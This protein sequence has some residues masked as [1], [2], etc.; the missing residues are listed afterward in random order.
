MTDAL[1]Q[2]ASTPVPD[3]SECS[4][5]GNG[6]PR[7][8]SALYLRRWLLDLQLKVQANE[9]AKHRMLKD[10]LHA[11]VQEAFG[12]QL[13]C[14]VSMA[15]TDLYEKLMANN[16]AVPDDELEQEEPLP[17]DFPKPDPE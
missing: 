1:Q 17:S 2:L 11:H 12:E 3:F 10:A 14:L 13:E 5:E 16:C 9:V 6:A 15:A 7:L 8:D 4:E